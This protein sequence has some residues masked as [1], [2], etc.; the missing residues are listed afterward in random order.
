M[1]QSASLHIQQRLVVRILGR[2][3]EEKFENEISLDLEEG[4]ELGM[5]LGCCE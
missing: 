5:K 2:R 3:I 4:K 1:V